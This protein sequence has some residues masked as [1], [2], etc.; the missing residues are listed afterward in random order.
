MEDNPK[1]MVNE[2]YPG[3]TMALKRK[4]SILKNFPLWKNY[5]KM[6][7]SGRRGENTKQKGRGEVNK[8]IFLY[9]IFTFVAG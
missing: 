4:G 9:C 7:M 1:I 8:T 5:R 6:K 3:H 2:I